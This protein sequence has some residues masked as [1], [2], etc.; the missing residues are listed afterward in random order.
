M[1]GQHGLVIGE[2]KALLEMR[3]RGH[4]DNALVFN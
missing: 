2:V 1:E 4:S 3:E